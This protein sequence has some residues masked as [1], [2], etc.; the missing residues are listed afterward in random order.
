[1]N[2]LCNILM[3]I[4]MNKSQYLI[5]YSK[6]CSIEYSI[7]Y[8]HKSLHSRCLLSLRYFLYFLWTA[9]CRLPSC[10]PT[11]FPSPARFHLPA[12]VAVAVLFSVVFRP[13]APRFQLLPHFSF[14]SLFVL[15]C[16]LLIHSNKLVFKLDF[17]KKLYLFLKKNPVNTVSIFAFA[18]MR[19]LSI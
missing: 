13:F 2:I 4:L 5:E 14:D 16:F 6:E 15:Y 9:F 18:I 11:E 17:V 7:E 12:F 1:M 19:W 10:L 3:N 8:F